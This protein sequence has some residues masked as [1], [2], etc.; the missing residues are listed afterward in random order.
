MNLKLLF[1]RDQK[2]LNF[3]FFISS[4]SRIGDQIFHSH[5]IGIETL[6]F[7]KDIFEFA[8][9]YFLRNSQQLP[10]FGLPRI[11]HGRDGI[12]QS[13]ITGHQKREIGPPR[14]QARLLASFPIYFLNKSHS[15]LRIAAAHFLLNTRGFF[16]IGLPKSSCHLNLRTQFWRVNFR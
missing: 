6:K 13:M 12:I 4:K 14:S 1:F 10:A 11:S 2:G 5:K 16:R 9:F 7:T 15:R 8:R 3:L